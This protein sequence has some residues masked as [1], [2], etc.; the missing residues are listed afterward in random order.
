MGAKWPT[1]DDVFNKKENGVVPKSSGAD[2]EGT[3]YLNEYGG[4]TVPEGGG[5]TA[6]ARLQ[7][8]DDTQLTDLTD[9][10][11]LMYDINTGV[12]KNKSL[13]ATPLNIPGFRKIYFGTE[14]LIP[15]ESPLAPGVI[16]MQYED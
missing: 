3:R 12:W 14:A 2:A 7:D 5:E 10:Q 9:D 8:L 11:T 6:P 15:G 1:R 16:Y 13:D 4:W